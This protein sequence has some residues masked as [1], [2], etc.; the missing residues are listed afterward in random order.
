MIGAGSTGIAIAKALHQ[1]G[2]DFDCFELGDRVGGNWVFRN[3]NGVSASYRSLHINTSRERMEFSD[4]PMPKAYPDFPRHDHIAEYFDSYV[5]HF[6][7][8]DRIRFGTAVEHVEPA[9][10]GGFDRPHERR[11]DRPLRRGRRRQRP[12]LGPALAGAAVPGARRLRGRADPL[13]LVR[14]RVSA[15]R[16]GRRR[17]RHGQLGDGHRRRRL[18]P[19]GEHIPGGASR[20]LH[21]AQIHHRQAPRSQGPRRP[22]ARGDPVPDHAAAAHAH[23]WA[24]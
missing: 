24:R 4:F 10:D 12:P 21:R 2:V 19:R 13:P 16:Q 15:R 20:R 14:A 17:A 18:L 11:R 5:D 22:P 6:G 23:R 7:F 8:R 3:S 1:R 9:E